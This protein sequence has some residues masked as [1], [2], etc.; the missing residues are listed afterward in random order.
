MRNCKMYPLPKPKWHTDILFPKRPCRHLT[1]NIYVRIH[2]NS[3]VELSVCSCLGS[4]NRIYFI[5]F[6]IFCFSSGCGLFHLFLRNDQRFASLQGIWWEE[7]RVLQVILS[8]LKFGKVGTLAFFLCFA[9]LI[10]PGWL[11]GGTS[12]L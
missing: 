2:S 3:I 7:A 10:F 1:P 4:I 9:L 6:I 11:L 12:F 5:P 8:S